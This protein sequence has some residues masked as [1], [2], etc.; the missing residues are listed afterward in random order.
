ME[1]LKALSAQV[2]RQRVAWRYDPV[3]LTKDYTI[4]RH[5]ETF[6][7]MAR[8]LA[9]FVDKCI[10][11]FVEMYRKLAVNMPE[12][13]P[14]SPPSG[15]SWRRVSE[16]SPQGT[17]CPCKFAAPTRIFPVLASAPPAA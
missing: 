14:V 9:P 16:P 13:R 6:G 1:T 2:G 17:A 10:F 7:A 8:E 3:L 15:R 5:L 11:S 4:P 12:L